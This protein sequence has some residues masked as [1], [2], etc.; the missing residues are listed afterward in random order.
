MPSPASRLTLT[1]ERRTAAETFLQGIVQVLGFTPHGSSHQ[2]FLRAQRTQSL[3]SPLTHKSLKMRGLWEL[4]LVR[5]GLGD[6]PSRVWQQ[7]RGMSPKGPTGN[8][9]VLGMSHPQISLCN[10]SALQGKGTIEGP[11]QQDWR[12]AGVERAGGQPGNVSNK[13]RA[14]WG[15]T[16]EE[17]PYNHKIVYS[18]RPRTRVWASA[19]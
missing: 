17:A 9:R 14:Q 18:V 8:C 5:V 1:Q 11:P 12:W 10:K 13:P 2:D 19:A 16:T 15:E 7:K 6:A 3:S 4:S